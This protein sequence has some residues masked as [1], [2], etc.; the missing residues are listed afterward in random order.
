MVTTM[1][2]SFQDYN[3]LV[4]IHKLI[5]LLTDTP[6]KNG[7]TSFFSFCSYEHICDRTMFHFREGVE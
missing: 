5:N 7:I 4:N 6:T 2:M 1:E 3:E